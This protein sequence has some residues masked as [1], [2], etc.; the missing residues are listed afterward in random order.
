MSLEVYLPKNPR[1][2][3]FTFADL[4]DEVMSERAIGHDWLTRRDLAGK[5][6]LG[7]IFLIANLDRHDLRGFH[8]RNRGDQ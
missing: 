8:W 3:F 5:D 4:D 7:L 1:A 6:R 2:A